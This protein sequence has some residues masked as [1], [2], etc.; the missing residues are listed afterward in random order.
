M[1][2]WE[3]LGFRKVLALMFLSIIQC[4]F[5]FSNSIKTRV[6]LKYFDV[7]TMQELKAISDVFEIKICESGGNESLTIKFDIKSTS[8]S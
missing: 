4:R 2:I 8:G 6:G 7:R 5:R 3:I 1:R